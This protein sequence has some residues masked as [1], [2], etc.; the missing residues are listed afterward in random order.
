MSAGAEIPGDA[1]PRLPRGVRLRS[2]EARGGHV[3]L[4]PE[5]VVR[6]DAVAVAILQLCDGS[7]TLDGL[8]DELCVV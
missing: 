7:R 5:R 8:V 1:R 4:A 6:T 3:L 2:D